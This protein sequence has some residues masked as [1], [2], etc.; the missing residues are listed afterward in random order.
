[1][2]IYIYTYN[3][4]NNNNDNA[5]HIIAINAAGLMR[6]FV[7]AAFGWL[8]NHPPPS[9]LGSV[10]SSDVGCIYIYIYMGAIRCDLAVD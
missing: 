3:N 4:N 2:Y 8:C 5:N 1:M 9:L 10:R 7:G 6:S